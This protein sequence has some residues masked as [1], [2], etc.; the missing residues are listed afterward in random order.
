[1][2]G[3]LCTALNEQVA[4]CVQPVMR[5]LLTALAD[6]EVH[7][8]AQPVTFSAFGDVAL[9]VGAAFTPYLPQVLPVL[10]AAIHSSRTHPQP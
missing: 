7:P 10:E 6:P 8:V 3:D 9:A 1:V 5:R 2:V 4:P